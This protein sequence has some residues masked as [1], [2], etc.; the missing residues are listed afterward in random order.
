MSTRVL[1]S[2]LLALAVA[3]AAAW[4][5][6]NEDTVQPAPIGTV[7]L[8]FENT[9][10]GSPIQLNQ[11]IYTNP[12]GTL[13][14]IS[15]LRYVV[16]DVTLHGTGGQT[17]GMDGIHYRSETNPATRTL[18]L[19]GVPKGTYNE[20][21]FTF[22]LDESKN[23]KDKYLN[24]PNEFHTEMEWPAAMGGDKGLGYHYMRLEGNFEDTPGGAT[25]GYTTHTGARW[26]ADGNPMTGVEDP[27][28]YHHYFTVRLPIGPITMDGDNWNVTLTMDVN[29][30]YE[31]ATPGDSFDSEYDW[32][33]LASQMVMANLAAQEK[34]EV[35]GPGCFTAVVNAMP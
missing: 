33:D 35:N 5:G 12:R 27:L 28:P 32:H 8:D 3:A 9:V 7:T 15:M 23:V 31:D 11:M 1:R 6:C 13:Y 24:A 25:V 16:S 22:G 26:L 19:D 29:G 18:V 21:S 30:W 20:I 14:S 2:C 10:S 34:L 4:A 17:Y